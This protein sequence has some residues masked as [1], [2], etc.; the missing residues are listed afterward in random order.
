MDMSI[1]KAQI[2]EELH[3][4]WTAQSI[5][6]AL[7]GRWDAAVQSNQEILKIFPNDVR[8]LNR[9][10]KAY[11]ELGRH[12]EA[13]AIYEKCLEQQPSNGIARRRLT[14]LY[15]ILQREPAKTLSTQPTDNEPGDDEV[16]DADAYPEE[17]ESEPGAGEDTAS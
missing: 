11:Q 6:M 1:S 3:R 17:E 9:L 15:A 7:L 12:E 8:A 5:E 2:K 14:E 4:Q 10:G 16:D 13:A